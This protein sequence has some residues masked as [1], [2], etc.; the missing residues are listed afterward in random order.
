MKKGL[1]IV[2]AFAILLSVLYII[3][4]NIPTDPYYWMGLMVVLGANPP[5]DLLGGHS[6]TDGFNEAASSTVYLI[7]YPARWMWYCG[8]QMSIITIWLTGKGGRI[9]P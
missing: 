3:P 9:I 4:Y 6:F 1:A 8:K 2:L 7:T 5:P